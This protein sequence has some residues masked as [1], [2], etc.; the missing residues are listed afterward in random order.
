M[1]KIWSPTGK[2]PVPA[3]Y[4][5]VL[6]DALEDHGIC[7]ECLLEDAGLAPELLV[8][9]SAHI[10]SS[11]F[12]RLIRRTIELTGDLSLGYRIGLWMNNSLCE[13]IDDMADYS[14]TL[15][16]ALQVCLAFSGLAE[17]PV[18]VS[19]QFMDDKAM[20]ELSTSGPDTSSENPAPSLL[21][22]AFASYAMTL[23]GRPVH[24]EGFLRRTEP[25]YFHLLRDH[26]P[27][28]VH[29]GQTS[30]RLEIP[31]SILK[32]PVRVPDG[33]ASPARSRRCRQE[34]V[35]ARANHSVAAL[36]RGLVFDEGLEIRSIENL[37]KS[38]G[39][40]P[41]T[42]QR[43]LREENIAF[44]DIVEEV[45]QE[46]S[47]KLLKEREFSI[48]EIARRLGYSDITNF[49]RA[50]RRWHGMTPR[51]YQS[52]VQILVARSSVNRNVM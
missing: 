43:Y 14:E 19:S 28:R 44:S 1:I 42:L 5:M 27:G 29:F 31:V 41:R 18:K 3:A 20:L 13:L 8:D 15:G 33:P 36:V 49:C 39:M 52:Q 9:F 16:D 24:G 45:R 2:K 7:G 40:S 37:S 17:S 23:C 32:W 21:M 6:M 50:F 46:Q 4:L 12:E 25:A 22:A 48:G 11:D 26:I 51:E 35:R 34:L 30:D 38:L 47:C 10:A